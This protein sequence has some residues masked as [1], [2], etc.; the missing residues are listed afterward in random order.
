MRWVHQGRSSVGI[1]CAGLVAVVA[2]NLGLAERHD[3]TSYQRNT[4]GYNFIKPFA[5]HMT[6]K[7]FKDRQPG[8]VLLFRDAQFPC[9]CGILGMDN[10]LIHAHAPDRKVVSTRLTEDWLDRAIVCFSFVGVDNG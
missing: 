9:H 6:R 8:D 5:D 10:K 1:D 3:D 7:N 4:T 2:S